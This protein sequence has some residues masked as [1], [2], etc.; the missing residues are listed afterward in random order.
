[1]NPTKPPQVGDVIANRYQ[2]VAEIG[3][4]GFGTIFEARQNRKPQQVALKLMSYQGS[5]MGPEEMKKRYRREAIMASNLIHPHTVQQLD[6]GD[7]GGYFYI[8]M[9]LLRG[10]TLGARINEQGPLDS[11]LIANIARAVLEVLQFAHQKDIVHR[12]LKPENI[13]LCD[14]D[15][16]VDVP[17]VL[18]FG[19]AKTMHGKHDLTSVGTALGSPAY[20]SPEVL[21]GQSPVPASDLYS[22]GLTLGEAIVGHKVVPGRS[23]IDR[24]KAQIS[25]DPLD[26]PEKLRNHDLYPWLAGALQKDTERRYATATAMLHALDQL[27][28][29]DITTARTEAMDAVSTTAPMQTNQRDSAPP[30]PDSEFSAQAT[31]VTASVGP[32]DKLQADEHPTETMA[33][34]P[35]LQSR[36]QAVKTPSSNDSADEDTEPFSPFGQSSDSAGDDTDVSPSYGSAFSSD[37]KSAP[38]ESNW[39]D[40]KYDDDQFEPTADKDFK[41]VK[42]AD[43]RKDRLF[44]PALLVGAVLL[45]L[46][47]LLV[48]SIAPG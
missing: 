41:I 11:E 9:E 5:D 33:V 48:S 31:V 43:G 2:L 47:Y 26:I 3:R 10:E 24:A 36:K 12:D 37:K 42:T 29:K 21:R 32:D 27:V 25:P 30:L 19:A 22:L 44:L 7:D 4:G 14:V 23:A 17:K 46:A 35:E 8:S 16:T 39:V 6:F 13:M 15:G 20:M 45:V 34:P 1:M 38:E 28:G 18:D 40:K